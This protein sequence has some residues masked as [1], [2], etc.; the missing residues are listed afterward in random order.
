MQFRIWCVPPRQYWETGSF[1]TENT[2]VVNWY[3]NN[4]FPFIHLSFLPWEFPQLYEITSSTVFYGIH[5]LLHSLFFFFFHLFFHFFFQITSFLNHCILVLFQKTL[6]FNNI[7]LIASVNNTHV[8][9][10]RGRS[11][12]TIPWFWFV[13]KCDID[14]DLSSRG[15]DRRVTH[16]EDHYANPAPPPPPSP[17]P[18]GCLRGSSRVSP[19]MA[20]EIIYIMMY[21]HN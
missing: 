7:N 19:L 13:Y 3:S 15:I 21:G 12:Q 8:G 17:L 9:K 5:A 20:V 11:C 14:R 6:T 18:T 1:S 16:T 10:F 4:G 2:W